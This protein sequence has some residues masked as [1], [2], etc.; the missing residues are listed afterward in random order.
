MKKPLALLALFAVCAVGG[1]AYGA[2]A[3]IWPTSPYGTAPG[4]GAVNNGGGTITFDV[5]LGSWEI[6]ATTYLPVPDTSAGL[7]SL[8]NFILYGHVA[9]WDDGLSDWVE[10]PEFAPPTMA[11]HQE[12]KDFY[13]AHHDDPWPRHELNPDGSIAY[14]DWLIVNRND[15]A[16]GM[17]ACSMYP[18]SI[19]K[20]GGAVTPPNPAY[21]GGLA[22]YTFDFDPTAEGLYKFYLEDQWEDF[23]GE[24]NTKSGVA[25]G[26]EF[27][28]TPMGRQQFVSF[29]PPPHWAISEFLAFGAYVGGEVTD[30]DMIPFDPAFDYTTGQFL[31][32]M[33]EEIIPEP[34]TLALLGVGLMGLAG[35]RRRK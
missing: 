34:T 10:A 17:L 21:Q 24:P 31:V 20:P 28:Y 29:P 18:S 25:W 8:N 5:W 14:T 2:F 12:L 33:G 16:L 1:S 4:T 15:P 35:L 9:K 6:G 30:W 13:M 7:P 26:T 23:G 22:T 27:S 32:E 19:T 3:N 11:V